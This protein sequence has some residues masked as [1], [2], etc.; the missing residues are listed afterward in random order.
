MKYSPNLKFCLYTLIET[1][2]WSPA[3]LG[4]TRAKGFCGY[5]LIT[6]TAI[7]VFS[8][9]FPWQIFVETPLEGHLKSESVK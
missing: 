9:E 8:L 4:F 7:P 3:L 6:L 1:S 2:I 5:F